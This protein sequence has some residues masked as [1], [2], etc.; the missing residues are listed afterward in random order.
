MK[1]IIKKPIVLILLSVIFLVSCRDEVLIEIDESNLKANTNLASLMQRTALNDGSNDNIID[2]AN[3]FNIQLPV[4]VIANGLEIIVNSE[5]DFETIED[6]FDEFDDDEDSIEIRFPYR[7]ILSDF[8]EMVIH[9]QGEHNGFRNA[10]NGENEID[11]D[12]E[13]LDFQYPI[14]GSIFNTTTEQTSRIVINNDKKMYDFIDDLGSDDVANIE[15]PI[16]VI[17]FDGSEVSISSLE[18]LE[19]VIENAKDDCDE[20]DDNDYNDDDCNGCSQQQILDI[21]TNCNDWTVDKL[22][23]NDNDLE[24]NYAGYTFNFSNDGMITVQENSNNFSGTWTSSGNGNNIIVVINISGLP[25]FNANWRLHEI[26]QN[27]SKN[28]VD[29]RLMDDR[30]RFESSSCN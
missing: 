28:K 24:D 18:Q 30:L 11:D 29:F 22:E 10:C 5:E 23:L 26:E 4:T 12:I 16:H 3:C 20:D 14:R 17:L 27:G 21:L 25:D 9:N 7:I 2:S 15:F 8:T 19:N 1:A 13:C 6:I